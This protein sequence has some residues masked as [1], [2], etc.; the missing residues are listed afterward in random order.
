MGLIP[1]SLGSKETRQRDK[2]N[3]FQEEKEKTWLVR[4]MPI[5]GFKRNSFG[6]FKKIINM[7][8]E[9]QG[10]RCRQKHLNGKNKK[11]KRH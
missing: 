4:I 7:G 3:C 11:G 9:R 1:K 2:K 5:L 6:D 8:D 10:E